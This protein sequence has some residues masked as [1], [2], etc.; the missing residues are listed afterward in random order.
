MPSRSMTD[1]SLA[2]VAEGC[3]ILQRR[4][5]FVVALL[6]VG[7]DDIQ[8]VGRSALE[9]GHQDFLALRG[10]FG[11]VHGALQPEGRGADSDHRQS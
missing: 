7:H 8:A 11:G 4:A 5:K 3:G 2:T 9:D 10:S 6:A 1:C